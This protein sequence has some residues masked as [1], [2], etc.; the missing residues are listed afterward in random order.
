MKYEKE[1]LKKPKFS[2]IFLRKFARNE[3]KFFE[4][5]LRKFGGKVNGYFWF[6]MVKVDKNEIW[7]KK[8]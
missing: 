4:I 6:G 8:L 3:P 5:F 7:K 2:E 1:K